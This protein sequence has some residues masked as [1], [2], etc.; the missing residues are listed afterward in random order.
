ML[1]NENSQDGKNAAQMSNLNV[2]CFQ[3]WGFYMG[4]VALT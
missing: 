4:R 1:D 2:V 3:L